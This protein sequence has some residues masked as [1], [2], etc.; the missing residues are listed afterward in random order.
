MSSITIDI[1]NY[2]FIGLTNEEIR[3]LLKRKHGAEFT[4]N[5][6]QGIIYDK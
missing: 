6:I 2:H 3:G 1:A 4:L 5:Q